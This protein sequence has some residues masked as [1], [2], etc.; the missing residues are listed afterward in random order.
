M[1]F[2]ELQTKLGPQQTSDWTRHNNGGGW[3]NKTAKVDSTAYIEGIVS[4]N[5]RVYGDAQVY[6]NARVSDNARVYDNAWEVSPLYIQ[7]TLYALTNCRKGHIQIGCECHPFEWWQ[8]N[9]LKLAEHE[10]FTE[11]QIMEYKAYVDLFERI[12]R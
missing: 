5:A 9:G 12:G 7:G 11:K 8:R 6:G 10:R 2:D 4:G 1:T 3:I